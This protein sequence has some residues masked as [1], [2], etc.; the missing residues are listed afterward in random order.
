MANI[1]W[2]K[3]E[4]QQQLDR[5]ARERWDTYGLLAYAAHNGTSTFSF[6]K[7]QT[8]IAGWL[9]E[10]GEEIGAHIKRQMQSPIGH[11]AALGLLL[12][13]PQEEQKKILTPELLERLYN[14]AWDEGIEEITSRWDKA[15]APT[16]PDVPAQQIKTATMRL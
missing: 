6:N 14:L 7:A 4:E 2:G 13:L 11:T 15:P 8:K 1:Q 3:S 16:T 9:P 10:W 5:L 12:V